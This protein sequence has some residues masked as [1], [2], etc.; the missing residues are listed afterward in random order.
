[1][2]DSVAG[3]VGV[4]LLEREPDVA[5]RY[6]HAAALLA[7]IARQEAAA[8]R[9]AAGASRARQ[10]AASLSAGRPGWR[11]LVVDDDPQIRLLCRL[12]LEAEG[13]QVV[14]AEDGEQAVRVALAS[15]PDVILLDVM[16]PGLDGWA[17]AERLRQEQATRGVALVF[18]TA[19]S[20]AEVEQRAH[21]HGGSYLGKPFDL[22]QLP[23]LVA[24]A[25][26]T[27]AR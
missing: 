1:M 7:L 12:N 15:P 23:G 14:E 25:A 24:E 27:T 19:L 26:A 4:R 8:L 5:E 22:I 9:R 18:V 2:G 17:V 13:F 10:P 6:G 20:G 11:V 16:M 3:S 21:S